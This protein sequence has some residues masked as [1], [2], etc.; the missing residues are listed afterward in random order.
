MTAHEL[1]TSD[2]ALANGPFRHD[3]LRAEDLVDAYA[4]TR[5]VAVDFLIRHGAVRLA[6][7]TGGLGRTGVP[8]IRIWALRNA[9]DWESAGAKSRTV[10]YLEQGAAA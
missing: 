8:P 6:R 5:P 7:Y 10:A 4:V 1:M 3:L 2:H 9:S